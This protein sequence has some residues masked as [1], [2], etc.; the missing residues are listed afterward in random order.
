MT[1]QSLT[2]LFKKLVFLN[3][4]K[5]SFDLRYDSKVISES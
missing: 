4:H 3:K 2:K 1:K 5:N